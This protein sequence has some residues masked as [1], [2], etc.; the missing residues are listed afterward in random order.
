MRVCRVAS[1]ED[2]EYLVD[3]LDFVRN[4]LNLLIGEIKKRIKA[5]TEEV[6]QKVVYTH[7]HAHTHTH[8]HTYT[9]TQTHTLTLAHMCFLG[10]STCKLN[11]CAFVLN[12]QL[13][14]VLV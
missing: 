10:L 8:T 5:I 12:I 2:R 7:A 6:E 1:M 13:L 14:L 3:R 4:Q 11:L 9:Y